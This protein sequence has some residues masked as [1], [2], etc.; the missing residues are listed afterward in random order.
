MMSYN[1]EV[2]A[3]TT[4]LG[5]MFFASTIFITLVITRYATLAKLIRDSRTEIEKGGLKFKNPEEFLFHLSHYEKRLRLLKATLYLSLWGGVELCLSF[6]FVLVKYDFI[7]LIFFALHVIF[8]LL[9]LIILVYELAVSFE[10][11]AEHLDI[12]KSWKDKFKLE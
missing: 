9:A 4:T 10:A 3:N 12:L 7:A 8:I 1:Y 2:I 11:L 5:T 6:L